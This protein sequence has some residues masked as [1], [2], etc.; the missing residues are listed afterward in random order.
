VYR[1][2]SPARRQGALSRDAARILAKTVLGQPRVPM[3]LVTG[4]TPI[5]MYRDFIPLHQEEELDFAMSS[6]ASDKLPRFTEGRS[7]VFLYVE[8]NFHR[9]FTPGRTSCTVAL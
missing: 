6:R 8:S 1:V 5:G 9:T 3:G 7:E 2:G 4:R